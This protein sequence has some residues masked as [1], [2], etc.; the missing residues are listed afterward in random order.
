MILSRLVLC[1]WLVCYITAC[2]CVTTLDA[3]P[4]IASEHQDDAV[5]ELKTAELKDCLLTCYR[6]RAEAVD[7]I[8][9][10]LSPL[11]IN[12]DQ[13]HMVDEFIAKSVA[14]NIDFIPKDTDVL[15]G[16]DDAVAITPEAHQLIDENEGVRV[17]YIV[18]HP[19]EW[20][21]FHI[22]CWKA[23]VIETQV[24]TFEIYRQDGSMFVDDSPPSVYELPPEE[25]NQ[26]PRNIGSSIYIGFRFEIKR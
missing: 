1:K 5:I 6:L 10:Q 22:H 7:F 24:S 26:S 12:V 17:L 18:S 11:L 4:M 20:V 15:P 3:V 8:V 9:T 23:L 13:H 21:P 14:L 25:Q 2:L 19:N 16:P